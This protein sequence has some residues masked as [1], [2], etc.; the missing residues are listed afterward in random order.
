MA[1]P[2]GSRAAV[3]R[4]VS[5]DAIVAPVGVSVAERLDR[6]VVV[7]LTAVGASVGA[8]PKS[9]PREK[10]G[11]PLREMNPNVRNPPA[12]STT[13]AT[14]ATVIRLIIGLPGWRWP[15]LRVRA[16]R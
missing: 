5:R 11:A 8:A 7:P 2:S 4:G 16:L 1:G 9:P 13:R 3:A 14:T 6:L 10:D 15:G 12:A